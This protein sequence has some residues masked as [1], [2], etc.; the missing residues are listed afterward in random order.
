MASKGV[1]RRQLEE[2]RQRLQQELRDLD[3]QQEPTR[4]SRLAREQTGYG[5]HMADDA[6]QTFE[7]EKDL[8]L[9][10]H[11]EGM[12]AQVEEALHRFDLSTYGRCENCG[13]EIDPAR[14]E[15][16]PWATLCLRC[17]ARS[18]ARR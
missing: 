10:Q 6:T 5:N 9:K 3:Q 18:E 7:D 13:Q 1:L 17:K 15:A 14:L 11:L 16:I 2:Q 4:D 12:L 8:A